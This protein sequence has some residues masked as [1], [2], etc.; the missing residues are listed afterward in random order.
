[1]FINPTDPVGGCNCEYFDVYI[2]Q[3]VCTQTHPHTHTH[4][5]YKQKHDNSQ[6]YLKTRKGVIRNVHD[7]YKL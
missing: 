1:M 2:S 5:P 3:H 6:I 7:G 4:T